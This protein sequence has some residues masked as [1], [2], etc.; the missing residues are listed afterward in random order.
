V[1]KLKDGHSFF[2]RSETS[3]FEM[4]T[5]PYM[6]SL[7]VKNDVSRWRGLKVNVFLNFFFQPRDLAESE[8][9]LHVFTFF[10]NS[11]KKPETGTVNFVLCL[12]FRLV[13]FFLL[14]C[15]AL[16]ISHDEFFGALFT[17]S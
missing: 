10:Q 13:F 4:R 8:K 1:T 3:F 16:K 9:A 7:Q 6:L 11:C 2:T 15:V 12:Y 5:K 14:G 17:P